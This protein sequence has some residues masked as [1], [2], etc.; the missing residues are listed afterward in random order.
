M[1]TYEAEV[2]LR[3]YSYFTNSGH[4]QFRPCWHEHTPG[5]YLWCF[6]L[7]VLFI[8]HAHVHYLQNVVVGTEFQSTN[9]NLNVVSQKVFSQLSHL[10][11]PC[12][13]PHQ[14]LSVRLTY[15]GGWNIW[16]IDVIKA[17]SFLNSLQTQM[18]LYPDL[19]NNFANLWLKAHVQHAVSF[20]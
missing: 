11:W 3:F 4:G 6:L 20:V 2:N 9:V 8:L 5:L 13:A 17:P 15:K 7:V 18:L 12:C 14:C 19:F 16:M 1:L 10:F